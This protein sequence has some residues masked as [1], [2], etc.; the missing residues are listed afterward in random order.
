MS[1]L[2]D[3]WSFDPFLIVAIVLVAWHEAGLARLARRSRPER[4]R[5]RRRRSFWFYGGLAVLLVAVES[6]VDY[7]ADDYFFAHMAQHLLLMFAAPTMIVAGAPWQPL[8]DGLPGRAGGLPNTEGLPQLST[9]A[10]AELNAVSHWASDLTGPAGA[11]C[12]SA[13]WP[14]TGPSRPA[15]PA[16]P[17]A[18]QRLGHDA[19]GQ[20]GPDTGQGRPP[21]KGGSAGQG[22]RA[23]SEEPG[24]RTGSGQQ[25]S[26]GGRG[27][28]SGQQGPDAGQR[29]VPGPRSRPGP[30][31]F[32]GRRSRERVMSGACGCPRRN[33]PPRSAR[34]RSRRATAR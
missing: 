5:E 24:Q 16:A 8:L 32:P 28:D 11:D 2:I 23:G 4:T 9:V 22:G 31:P 25:G 20:Q 26:D 34:R 13:P 29:P 10:S 6:P 21:G 15:P 17:A 3:H 12:G 1:Y 30:V 7:W 18:G 19:V 33:R 14:S 27:A